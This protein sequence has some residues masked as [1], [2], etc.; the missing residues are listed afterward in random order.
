MKYL[1]PEIAA[2]S[3][4]FEESK[5]LVLKNNSCGIFQ[6]LDYKKQST[7]AKEDKKKL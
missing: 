1:S 2:L 5:S 3:K 6:N 7:L 4:K